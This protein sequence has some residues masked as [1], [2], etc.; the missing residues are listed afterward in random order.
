MGLLTPVQRGKFL[1]VLRKWH[2]EE[3]EKYEKTEKK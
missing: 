2:H 3:R 1:M